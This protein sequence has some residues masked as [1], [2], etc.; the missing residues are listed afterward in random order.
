MKHALLL[1][2]AFC[3]FALPAAADTL[4]LKRVAIST[5]GLALFE[6]QGSVAGATEIEIPVRLDAVDDVLKS[7]VVLDSSGGFGGVTL[8]G[9]E[10]LSQSF[11][12]LPFSRE[13]LNSPISLMNA[14]QGA[15]IEIT[16]AT[17]IKG[18]LMNV[19]P[20][21]TTTEDG[22]S[23]T[24]HRV[25]VVT[26]EGVKTALLENLNNVRFTEAT[27]QNQIDR[28]LEAVYTN[29]IRDQRAL[30]ISLKGTDTRPVG[31]T[32]VQA[33]PLW[34]SA[35]RLVMPEGS[36]KAF[37]QGWAILENTTGIDWNKVEVTLLSGAPVTYRQS[38]YESYYLSRPELPVKVMDRIMPRV[39]SGS[40]GDVGS[41][42]GYI[43]NEMLREESDAVMKKERRAN[44]PA[45]AL[46]AKMAMAD[47]AVSMESMGYGGAPPM[48]A[49]VPMDM[50]QA[51]MAV[52]QDAATQMVFTFPEPVTL[53]AGNSLMVPFVSRELPAERVWL[54]QPETNQGHPLAAVEM[55]NNGETGLPPGILTLYE[56]TGVQKATLHVGDA[57]MPMV[58][59]SESRFISYALDTKTK[60]TQEAQDDRQ[61]GLL[62]ISKGLM[63]HK[64][65]WRN[66]TKYTIK[67][68]AE[69]DRTI[70]IEHPRRPDWEMVTPE[71]MDGEP[72]MTDT[73]YRVKVSVPKGK[74]K[75]LS[76][77][78][79]RDDTEVI[80]LNGIS[81]Y[82]IDNRISLS[83]KDLKPEVRRALEKIKELQ[84]TVY[85]AQ[86]D[87]NRIEEKR[88]E[89][90]RDQERLRENL[91]TVAANNELGKRYLKELNDQEDALARIKKD[92]EAG[93]QRLNAAQETLSDYI[94]TLEF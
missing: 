17:T 68:P 81:P 57:E 69:E 35:Y 44:A 34:K 2:T 91:K 13:D 47:S 61:F 72:E 90:F 58:P 50:A 87:I 93:Q 94:G 30:T 36:D 16:G 27:V 12:D 25:S 60:I 76:L 14:L 65:L 67:A 52:A 18:R 15:E 7:L 38:L 70:V 33:A 55:D 89:I 40:M 28:A 20:E 78:L 5:S 10:P 85:S 92:Q 37:L 74:T 31:I 8:P 3:V 21:T 4:P 73:H 1:T 64:V 62:T 83:G 24:R 75:T 51:T 84:N 77:T 39:D 80:S 42:E 9:R 82:E 63:N 56:Q 49:A 46:M 19:V 79:Q 23:I 86:N 26:A 48:P 59:K 45:P 22:E 6:H 66:T 43:E 29:R 88:Q 54:Y 53:A 41:I 11:R 32:Y 71:E